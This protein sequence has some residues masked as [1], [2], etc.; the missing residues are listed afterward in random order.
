[1][2]KIKKPKNSM[3]EPCQHGK[4]TRVEIKTKEYSTTR[5]LE[6]VH[7]DLCGPR[8]SKGLNGEEYFM[9]CFILLNSFLSSLFFFLSLFSSSKEL[10]NS[11]SRSTSPSSLDSSRPSM[12]Y[13]VSMAI[14]STFSK[15]SSLSESSSDEL[16]SSFE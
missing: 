10:I 5:P 3:C 4:N 16:L 14:K 6:L 8:R 7:T 11:P 13:F 15:S 1:M 2:S 9:L 12:I